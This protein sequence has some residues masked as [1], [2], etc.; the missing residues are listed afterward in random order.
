M[1]GT[2][3]QNGVH[4]PNA[5]GAGSSPEREGGGHAAS[6][7][8]PNA[9]PEGTPGLQGPPQ[10]VADFNAWIKQYSIGMPLDQLNA[11]LPRMQARNV[12]PDAETFRLLLE[13]HAR[14]ECSGGVPQVLYAM[15]RF[16]VEVSP[17]LMRA[18]IVA[19]TGQ[20]GDIAP[21]PQIL[22]VLR[23]TRCC[24]AGLDTY[25]A[26]I[27]AYGELQCGDA[28]DDLV[29]VLVHDER[30][31]DLSRML[32]A[33][34]EA[35][36]VDVAQQVLH[37]MVWNHRM[38]DDAAFEAVVRAGCKLS[39]VDRVERM[40]RVLRETGCGKNKHY[41]MLLN[42]YIS[43]QQLDRVS[44]V[45][46]S[47]MEA[48]LA[49]DVVT[50]TSLLHAYGKARQLDRVAEIFAMMKHMGVTPTAVTYNT[51]L[52]IYGRHQ[53]TARVQQLCLEMLETG[54]PLDLT[55]YNTL[56]SMHCK[57]GDVAQLEVVMEAMHHN[58][59]KPDAV[60]FNI[61]LNAYC[62]A[63]NFEGIQEVI[64]LMQVGPP[65]SLMQV[66]PLSPIPGT[67]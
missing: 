58:R 34:C 20:G 12:S 11:I 57:A 44:W 40:F 45:L 4:E 38:P 19:W 7:Q 33:L 35:D 22:A 10:D 51:L 66:P 30:G 39:A 13:A 1:K 2:A 52:A 6:W 25:L 67:M 23:D 27:R 59:L 18:L 62:K 21:V 15:A 16:P 3:D 48:G 26:L 36:Q 42:A 54:F 29:N 9:N 50:F 61:L 37:G 28:I 64:S 49:P 24:P 32:V 41:N 5:N 53:Q 65:A 17:V 63:K 60:S 46:A 47:M 55:T 8:Q 31:V 56:L 14:F 43:A